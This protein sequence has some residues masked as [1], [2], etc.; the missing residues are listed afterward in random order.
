[1]KKYLIRKNSHKILQQTPVSFL[2]LGFVNVIRR[3]ARKFM[4]GLV[5]P[6]DMPDGL[7]DSVE[8]MRKMV[9]EAVAETDDELIEK[10][11]QMMSS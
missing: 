11:L 2:Y 10:F 7:D 8:T 6:C 3:A 5:E 9:E 4:N 1:M